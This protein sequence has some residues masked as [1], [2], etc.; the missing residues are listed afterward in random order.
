MYYVKRVLVFIALALMGI[1]TAACS[2]GSPAPVVTVTAQAPAPQAPSQDELFVAQIRVQAPVA[3]AGESDAAILDLGH[4]ICNALS[5]GASV[6]DVAGVLVPM[7]VQEGGAF[8]G[9]S[10][11]ILCP[12]NGPKLSA[13]GGTS[14]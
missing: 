13:A 9:L 5:S 14:V 10:V 7:G 2:G 11:A 12:E 1:T 4:N 6:D 3:T 8:L